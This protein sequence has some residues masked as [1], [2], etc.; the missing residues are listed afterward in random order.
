MPGMAMTNEPTATPDTRRVLRRRLATQ[1]LTA[2]GLD[3]AVD[4]VR[5][6]CCIQAQE[7][8]S[9]VYSLGLRIGRR[10]APTL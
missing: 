7:P 6:M 3:S 2:G 9:A 1:R 4:V 10:S 5:L 8:I